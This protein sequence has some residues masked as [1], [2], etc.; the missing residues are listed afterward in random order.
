MKP[1]C[2]SSSPTFVALYLFCF[3]HSSVCLVVSHCG[4]ILN[5]LMVWIK[6]PFIFNY[7]AFPNDF[8][9]DLVIKWI[10]QH[11]MSSVAGSL[12]EHLPGFILFISLWL[13]IKVSPQSSWRAITQLPAPHKCSVGPSGVPIQRFGVIPNM[14]GLLGSSFHFFSFFVAHSAGLALPTFI[15]F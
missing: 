1:S 15:L 10:F 11:L 9:S 7:Y 5:F 6:L 14:V 12:T 3:S 2:S 4:S 13:H 8:L